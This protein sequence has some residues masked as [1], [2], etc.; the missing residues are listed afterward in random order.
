MVVTVTK[1]LHKFLTKNS[2]YG[3][4]SLFPTMSANS[5]L[6]FGYGSPSLGMVW[7]LSVDLALLMSD[8]EAMNEGKVRPF[9]TDVPRRMK[10]K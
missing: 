3:D 7:R 8:A 9:A 5:G 4:S 6:S 10:M 1:V 2:V